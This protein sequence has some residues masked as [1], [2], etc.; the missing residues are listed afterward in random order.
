MSRRRFALSTAGMYAGLLVAF[1]SPL[2]GAGFFAA[3]VWYGMKG[4]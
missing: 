1:Y 2:I 4:K 3:A